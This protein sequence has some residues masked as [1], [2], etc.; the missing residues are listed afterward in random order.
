MNKQSIQ[1][2]NHNKSAK[3]CLF[4]VGDTIYVMN[5]ASSTTWL[6]RVLQD[7][8]EHA[9]LDDSNK[10]KTKDIDTDTNTRKSKTISKPI[11]YIKCYDFACILTLLKYVMFMYFHC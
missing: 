8:I 6:K 9:L 3:D 5:F 1:L 11:T 2:N 4:F 7:H 10:I